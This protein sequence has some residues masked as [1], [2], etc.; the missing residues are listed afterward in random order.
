MENRYSQ[1][2]R[3]TIVVFCTVIILCLIIVVA[4]RI[5]FTIGYSV[6]IVLLVQSLLRKM[7]GL[8]KIKSRLFRAMV[9]IILYVFVMTVAGYLIFIGLVYCFNTIVEVLSS[10]NDISDQLEKLTDS[11]VINA[12]INSIYSELLSIIKS[13][14]GDSVEA[15]MNF[16]NRLLDMFFTILFSLLLVVDYYR[17]KEYT[18]KLLGNYYNIA[19]QNVRIIKESFFKIIKSYFMIFICTFLMLFIGFLIIGNQNAFIHA[20]VISLI[21]FLPILGLELVLIPWIV[22]LFIIGNYL[23]MIK[24]LVMY[25]IIVIVKRVLENKLFSDASNIHPLA[26]I[27]LLYTCYKVFG[28]IGFIIA[29]FLAIWIKQI[30]VKGHKDYE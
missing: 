28:T 3:T 22:Y 21:D 30:Y 9:T 24:L 29:P 19:L 6:M 1:I 14:M 20:L 12:V 13:I 27:M 7:E 23:Y 10:Y 4:S 15:I 16:P 25:I 2:I 18:Q 8:V 26:M 11:T 5:F 17:I